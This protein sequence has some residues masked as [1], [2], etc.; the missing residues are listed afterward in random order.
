MNA[1]LVSK[2]AY[3]AISS[4]E[5]LVCRFEAAGKKMSKCQDRVQSGRAETKIG[6]FESSSGRFWLFSGSLAPH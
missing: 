4:F 2:G 5:E 6:H 1:C 3:T